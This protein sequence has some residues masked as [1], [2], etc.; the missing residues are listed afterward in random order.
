MYLF[1]YYVYALEDDDCAFNLQSTQYILKSFMMLVVPYARA[2]MSGPRSSD[3]PTWLRQARPVTPPRNPGY[4]LVPIPAHIPRGDRSRS[5]RP[6][7]TEVL[8]RHHSRRPLNFQLGR[9]TLRLYGDGRRM[10]TILLC[11]VCQLNG[12]DWSYEH[13]FETV[14]ATGCVRIRCSKCAVTWGTFRWWGV[15]IYIHMSIYI[16]IYIY[17]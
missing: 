5:P 16:Y 11:N 2:T 9:S 7:A 10:D 14:A 17:I 1:W 13:F 8:T 4:I 6:S 15:L 3:L 12:D